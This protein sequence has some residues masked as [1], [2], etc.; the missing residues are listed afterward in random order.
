[1][2]EY[3]A[4]APAN[5]PAIMATE[6]PAALSAEMLD[7]VK[8]MFLR[9][10]DV[11]NNSRELYGRHIALF[12]DWIM[13]RGLDVSKITR[14]D[15]IRYKEDLLRDHAPLTVASYLVTVRRFFAWTEGIKLYPN[16]AK[17]VK[18]PRRKQEF[19]KEDLTDYNEKTGAW[20]TSKVTALLEFGRERSPRDYA[21]I[22][23]L[24]RCGLRTIELIRLNVGDVTYK[25]GQRVLKIWGKGHDGKDETVDLTEKAFAAIAEY[26]KTRG[27]NGDYDNP[28][29]PWFNEPL[30][31]SVGNRNANGRLSTRSVRRLAKDG[32]RAIG[33][34]SRQYTAHSL[35][36]TTACLMLENGTDI[37]EI[38]RVLRHTNTNTTQI[39]V[40]SIAEKQR[41]QHAAIRVL[42]DVI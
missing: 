9:D 26:L 40:E 19:I 34:N 29:A 13:T 14:A 5:V 30:F 1:M 42:D 6:T 12:F 7:A 35:R 25:Y 33:L 16:V 3:I 39:Y 22:S 27:I 10:Q 15:I 17:D 11:R 36:H 8:D 20:D 2:V 31:A 28:R 21:I 32:L 24:V 4:P 38:K 37:F 41:I 18:S 23:T